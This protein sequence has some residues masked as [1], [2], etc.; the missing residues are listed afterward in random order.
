MP[1][2]LTFGEYILFFWIAENG[3][4]VHVHVSVRRATEHATKFWL[5]SKGGCILANNHSQ[6][7]EKDLRDIAKF[8]TLN[9]R[10]I[11]KCW[12]ERFGTDALTFYC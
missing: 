7:P 9:H 8:I 2:I 10:Y 5:T 1:R 12:I 6:I 4:L 11:C 3:E